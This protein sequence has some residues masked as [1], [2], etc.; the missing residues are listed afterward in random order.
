MKILRCIDT[1]PYPL[2]DF[3][4]NLVK[5]FSIK[6]IITKEGL[7]AAFAI[8]FFYAL[9]YICGVGCPIKYLTGI[10]CAGCGMTR[11]WIHF[12]QL[13][14]QGAFYYHPLFLLPIPG[15]IIFLFR[16]YIKKNILKYLIFIGIILFLVV[17][18]I[19]MFNEADSIVVFEPQNS[20][21]IRIFNTLVKGDNYVL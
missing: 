3:I 6:K 1:I 2:Y 15:G 13:D 10:S 8:I 11:A 21:P 14:L 19:R 16:N 9:L 7:F 5:Q 20:L 4:M 18:I 17:Y 12:L